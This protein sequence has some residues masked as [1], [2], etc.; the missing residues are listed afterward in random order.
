MSSSPTITFS[1]LSKL[2]PTTKIFQ[3]NPTLHSVKCPNTELLLVRIFL[4]LTECR[5]TRTRN[6]SVVEHFSRS[7]IVRL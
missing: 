3:K 5:K 2:L 6:D 7:V 1:L 4:Y